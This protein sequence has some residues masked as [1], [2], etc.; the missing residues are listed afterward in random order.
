M[1]AKSPMKNG[2]MVNLSSDTTVEL[3]EETQAPQW[4]LDAFSSM[5]LKEITF[6]YSS[7]NCDA[8]RIVEILTR[9]NRSTTSPASFSGSLDES[10]ENENSIL[11]M[12]P[13]KKDVLNQKSMTVHHTLK[14]SNAR[15]DTRKIKV[16]EVGT[17]LEMTGTTNSLQERQ[18]E[19][20]LDSM[21]GDGCELDM[22]II[23]DVLSQ[24]EYDVQKSLDR[25]LDM[26]A[27]SLFQYENGF[28]NTSNG[29]SGGDKEGLIK[30]SYRVISES[31]LDS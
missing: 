24:S 4:L 22:D 9:L 11:K 7:A 30:I 29:V 27:T 17:P 18:V 23:R 25:L 16:D 5:S 26:A 21:M 31:F 14:S 20:F 3:D 12:F 10:L 8:S 13:K 6:T 19:D 1:V 28:V 15:K 2:N